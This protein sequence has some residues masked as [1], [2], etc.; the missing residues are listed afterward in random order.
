MA[1]SQAFNISHGN[2]QKLMYWKTMFDLY[3][4]INSTIYSSKFMK[5]MALYLCHCFSPVVHH[6]QIFDYCRCRGIIHISGPLRGN[7]LAASI[8]DLIPDLQVLLSWG[9]TVVSF[10]SQQSFSVS[11]F[12]VSFAPLPHSVVGHLYSVLIFVFH[13]QVVYKC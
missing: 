4:C 2:W 1:K 8:A 11:F 10:H 12:H 9:S 13:G 3:Y 5:T 7:W 6:D